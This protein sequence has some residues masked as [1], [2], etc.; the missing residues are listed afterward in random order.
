M[1]VYGWEV[2]RFKVIKQEGVEWPKGRRL[3][4]IWFAYIQVVI[5]ENKVRIFQLL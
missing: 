2:I 4:I 3:Y 5:C 1:N